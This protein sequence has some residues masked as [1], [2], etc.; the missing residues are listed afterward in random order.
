MKVWSIIICALLVCM[1]CSEHVFESNKSLNQMTGEK[2]NFDF[3]ELRFEE[4][5]INFQNKIFESDDLNYFTYEY[6]Y[7]GG[8]V[9]IADFDNDGLEDL[10]F[11]CYMGFNRFYK[12]NG[13]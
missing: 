3:R 5:G 13:G 1:G 4:T 9:S 8:G 10:L 7:N 2:L 12:N 6:L 11:T